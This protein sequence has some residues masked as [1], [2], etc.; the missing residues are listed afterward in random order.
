MDE[1]VC[2]EPRALQE[3]SGSHM[4]ETQ[5]A[6]YWYP[7]QHLVRGTFDSMASSCQVLLDTDDIEKAAAI[8]RTVYEQ[9]R[10]IEHKF[11]R[12]R[13][14]SVVGQLNLRAGTTVD[15]DEETHRLLTFAQELYLMSDGLFDVTSGA[16]RRVWRF[17]GTSGVP[18]AAAVDAVRP[19]I[20][21]HQV[22]LA[23]DTFYMPEG[24]E[25][26]LGGIGKE[27]AVDCAYACIEQMDDVAFLVN[28]GGDL[29]CK[30]PR[31]SGA[32]WMIGIEHPERSAVSVLELELSQCALATS[33]DTKRCIIEGGVRYGHIL[34][35][36]TGWPVQSVARS[37]TVQAGTCTQ[38][39]MLSTLALLHGAQA[40]SF[41][42]AQSD[43][44][45]WLTQAEPL[46]D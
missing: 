37:V 10:R 45:F 23:A 39:G 19:S 38:A 27:Y 32:G 35:P 5:V 29:R 34:N 7:D 14:D 26:D 20:G 25:L 36:K 16:L 4:S 44:R 31:V 40:R 24:M 21:W 18:S 8:V 28:F 17:D 30:G 1:R 33:G 11:S 41:L 15:V 46:G 42:E 9:T 43:I 22:H 6:V 2:F 12:Y 3:A 13:A